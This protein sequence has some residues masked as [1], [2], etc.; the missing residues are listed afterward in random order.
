MAG[1]IG[2]LNVDRVHLVGEIG[3]VVILPPFQRTHVATHANALLLHYCLDLGVMRVWSSE[4]QAFVAPQASDPK[5][6][7]LG[8]R[9]LQWQA[10][11]GNLPS[12]NASQR[13]GFR[14]EG[15]ARC[16]RILKTP[17][18]DE[19]GRPGDGSEFGSRS[20]WI[21]AMTWRDW[22]EGGVRENIDVL[23]AR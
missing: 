1:V 2:L 6:R 14:A 23:V 13:L 9:R 18:G 20:S 21:G 10:H 7:P 22:E 19:S 17:D 11:H 15:I 4:Y 16:Q 3:H 5:Q 12:Q 8:L